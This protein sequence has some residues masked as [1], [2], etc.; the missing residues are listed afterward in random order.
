MTG[1]PY[2]SGEAVE[3]RR[4][5]AS[6][7][8]WSNAVTVARQWKRCDA[9]G[10]ACAPIAGAT[11]Q[12]YQPSSGDLGRRLLVEVT[13][14]N[15]VGETTTVQ[16]PTSQQVRAKPSSTGGFTPQ[17]GQNGAN[18]LNGTNGSNGSVGAAGV[19]ANGFGASRG[20]RLV[21]VVSERGGSLRTVFGRRV[22]ISGRLVDEH[23]AAIRSARVAV[24]ATP[25]VPRAVGMPE[26]SVTTD[27]QGRFSYMA[28]AGPSRE[29]TFGYRAFSEDRELSS[30]TKVLV[31][32]RATG[33]LRA[34]PRTLRNGQ[35]VT[36][37]G[38][39][40]GGLLPRGGVVVDVQAKVCRGARGT[41]R[42]EW[43][44]IRSPRTNAKGQ[45]RAS[46]RFTRT[47]R[48]TVYQFRSVVRQ[49]SDWPFLG[50]KIG[51]SAKV[52]VK[53]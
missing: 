14:R 48:R 18:G 23:G 53:R 25:H 41:G 9:D 19:G 8:V 36:F 2:I 43:R 6:D 30:E 21:G 52:T 50:G 22:T 38:G 1:S 20:A 49:D 35:K 10:L 31:L 28:P 11:G 46:Y 12:E 4:L 3:E 45:F 29:L 40:N 51:N 34:A 24:T 5:V 17:P 37:T 44:T 13:A 27:D 32:V 7:G 47:F 26:G 15:G 42:C 33:L 16:S 39:V